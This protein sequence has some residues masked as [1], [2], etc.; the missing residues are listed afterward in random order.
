MAQP[1]IAIVGGL[2]LIG[3]IAFALRQGMKVTPDD[4]PDRSGQTNYG[5]GGGDTSI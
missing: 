2:L 4:R 3:F 1:I 5:G